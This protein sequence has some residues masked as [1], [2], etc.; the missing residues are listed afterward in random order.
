MLPNLQGQEMNKPI[1]NMYMQS[2]LNSDLG[3]RFSEL[4]IEVN[5]PNANQSKLDMLEDIISIDP[6]YSMIYASS[7]NARFIKGEKSIAKNAWTSLCYARSILK[8]RFLAGE[9]AI[10]DSKNST[11]HD[12]NAYKLYLD[13]L[14]MRDPIVALKEDAIFGVFPPAKKAKR[15]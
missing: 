15:N 12:R 9:A 7:I 14:S 3:N 13:I 1:D 10:I 6:A 2:L 8:G 5:S 4:M 11:G